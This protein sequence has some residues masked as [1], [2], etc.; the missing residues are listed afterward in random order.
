MGGIGKSTIADV[1][2]HRLSS[3]FEACC[4]IPNVREASETRQGLNELRNQL[5]RT[6]LKEE[7]LH[8]ATP[9]IGPTF[10]R[11]R[12]SC[13]KVLVVLDDVCD[14]DQVEFLVGGDRIL[15]GPGSRIIVTARNKRTLGV[16]DNMIYNVKELDCDEA[17][18]LF[19]LRALRNFSPTTD[20]ATLSRE[21]VEYAGGNPLALTVL[22]SVF[23]HCKSKEDWQSELDK[24]KKY[25]DTKIHDVLRFSY[26]GLGKNEREIF[27]DIACYHKGKYIEEAK[28][29]L[30]ACGFSANA[31][32]VV[33][34]QCD[35]NP[36][37]RSRLWCANEICGVLKKK[38]VL[39]PLSA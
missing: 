24:L 23:F 6:L 38:R 10:V 35:K 25:P 27:L 37:K 16:D 14:L 17:L 11:Q 8:V 32:K 30:E 7:N 20:H 3:Q 34:D 2:F 21:V 5:L 36:G 31:G 19:H 28:R 33:R 18:D 12:L 13:T 4:F 1:V 39:K 15:F 22:G 29:I 9:S 26:D